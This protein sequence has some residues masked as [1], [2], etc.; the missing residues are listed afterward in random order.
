MPWLQR[1]TAVNLTLPGAQAPLP[2][3][4]LSM[5]HVC[6]TGLLLSDFK[7]R[8]LDQSRNGTHELKHRLLRFMVLVETRVGFHIQSLGACALQ[9]LAQIKRGGRQVLSLPG[10]PG[11]HQNVV[12]V[13]CFAGG[14]AGGKRMGAAV[15][16]R[17]RAV[18][19]IWIGGLKV[20]NTDACSQGGWSHS[21][22]EDM[23]S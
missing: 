5:I 14:C 9:E 2:K 19:K 13:C 23:P 6:S 12:Q 8:S 18:E 16:E 4:A 7:W 15:W 1:E 22:K 20:H 17:R 21:C 3:D 10:Q 11:L